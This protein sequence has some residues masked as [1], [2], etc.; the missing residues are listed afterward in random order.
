M[1]YGAVIKF[2]INV[3]QEVHHGLRGVLEVEFE[4]DLAFGC[5]QYNLG[6]FDR[7]VRRTAHQRNAKKNQYRY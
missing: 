3:I 1:E 2:G 6:I 4:H 7:F 5:V